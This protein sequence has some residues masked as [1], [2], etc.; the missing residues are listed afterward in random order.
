[1]IDWNL[2]DKSACVRR[3]NHMTRGWFAL[4]NGFRLVEGVRA[5]GMLNGMDK[6]PLMRDIGCDKNRPLVQCC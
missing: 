6:V 5:R 3:L 1:M 4:L 2:F